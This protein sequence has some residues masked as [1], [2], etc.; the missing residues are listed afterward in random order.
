MSRWRPSQWLRHGRSFHWRI[1]PRGVQQE[2]PNSTTKVAS[3]IQV[4][5]DHLGPLSACGDSTRPGP[6]TTPPGIDHG[7]QQQQDRSG[8]GTT[9]RWV[10]SLG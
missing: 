3:T 2:G 6:A 1:G 7:E 9:T 5:L 8:A 10:V 4:V